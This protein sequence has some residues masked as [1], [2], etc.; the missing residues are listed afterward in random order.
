[1]KNLVSKMDWRVRP[2]RVPTSLKVKMN[3]DWRRKNEN[4]IERGVNYDVTKCPH[5]SHVMHLYS[6]TWQLRVKWSIS[7][8]EN[9][10]CLQNYNL[11]PHASGNNISQIQKSYGWR[12]LEPYLKRLEIPGH[13]RISLMM[14]P[15]SHAQFVDSMTRYTLCTT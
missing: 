10:F 5:R 3:L 1:M 11:Q 4:E 8:R 7:G 15:Q 13:L 14:R 2:S 9:I 12:R 6:I